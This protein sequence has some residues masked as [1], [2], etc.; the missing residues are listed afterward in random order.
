MEGRERKVLPYYPS[1]DPFLGCGRVAWRFNR[2][3][4]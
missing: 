3:F 2:M 1:M 4:T